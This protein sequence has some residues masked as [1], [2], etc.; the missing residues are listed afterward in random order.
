MK[1]KEVLSSPGERYRERLETGEGGRGDWRGTEVGE[2]VR[3]K[4]EL[5]RRRL[6]PLRTFSS[7]SSSSPTTFPSSSPTSISCD[8]STSSSS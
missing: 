4:E 3:P 2:E 5:E 6:F 8:P 7:S 1:E